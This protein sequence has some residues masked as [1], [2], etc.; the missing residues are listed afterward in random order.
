M[1]VVKR[2]ASPTPLSANP[3]RKRMAVER[4]V[5]TPKR[6]WSRAPPASSIPEMKSE[7]LH[8]ADALEW[9]LKRPKWGTVTQAEWD[10]MS[11]RMYAL[12]HLNFAFWDESEID[13]IEAYIHRFYQDSRVV[14]DEVFHRN[15]R[16]AASA[17]KYYFS[18]IVKRYTLDE[19]RAERMG[20]KQAIREGVARVVDS[21][22]H[23]EGEDDDESE[24]SRLIRL[25]DMVEDLREK[26]GFRRSAG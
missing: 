19:E 11:R 18:H 7:K 10:E 24:E 20:L 21:P 22:V 12:P 8:D 16:N 5:A 13:V 26:R 1:R 25:M 17:Y 15:W 6:M 2:A 23:E 4:G 9:S 14:D 3:A